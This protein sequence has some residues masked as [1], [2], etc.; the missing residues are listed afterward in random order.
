MIMLYILYFFIGLLVLSFIF[1]I[2]HSF[3]VARTIQALHE[4]GGYKELAKSFGISD[5]YESQVA[6][7]LALFKEDQENKYRT[8]KNISNELD[9][10]HSRLNDLQIQI[11][12]LNYVN[13]KKLNKLRVKISKK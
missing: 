1:S 7:N 9:Y 12:D 11:S 4:V 6:I 10:A 8:I 13:R 3:D 2:W 5:E